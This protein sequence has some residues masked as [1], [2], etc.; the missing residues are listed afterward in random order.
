MKFQRMLP[1][2]FAALLLAVGA[3][4]AACGGDEKLSL[5]EY[6][7]Q[8]QASSD[9]VNER[10]ETLFEDLGAVFDPSVSEEERLEAAP[11][12]ADELVSVVSFAFDEASELDPPSEVEDAH[13]EFVEA[14]GDFAEA[15]Q[16]LA[17]SVAEAESV[18]DVQEL[19]EGNPVLDAAD[20]RFTDACQALEGIAADNGFE[21]TLECE[22]EE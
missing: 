18:A 3:M 17:V 16:G 7:L 11:K 9:E 6:F 4:A 22:D 2:L 8:L 21:L 20:K 1:L 19:L 15:V 12:F 14:L 10:F 5:E 13:N